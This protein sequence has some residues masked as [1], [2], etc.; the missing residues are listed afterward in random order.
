MIKKLVS[1]FF[2]L[3]FVTLSAQRNSTSSPYS[4][5]GLGEQFSPRTIEQSAMGG[6]GVAFN[7]YKYLNFTNPAAIAEIRYTTYT[8]GVLN[9][10]LT[11]KDVNTSQSGNATNLSYF[12]LA[13]PI[14]KKAGASLGIQPVSSVGYG[15]NNTVLD[16]DGNF[17]EFSSFSGNGGVSRVYGTFGLKV[18]KEL[19][20]G[21]EAGFSFGNTENT[22]T[23][24]RTGVTLFTEFN[25]ETQIR[26][27]VVKVGAQ[28]NKEL[29]NKLRI[30]A[31]ASAKLGN[32]L[33]V[34][35][36]EYLYSVGFNGNGVR[37]SRDTILDNPVTGKYTLPLKITLGAGVGKYDKWYVGVEY[38]GQDAI[39]T[40]GFL[41][42]SSAAF[43][44]GNSNRFSLGG[45][46]LPKMNSISS[47][48]ERVTY[49]AGIRLEK[50][51]L[52][53]DGSGTN[54]NF[55]PID[56]FGISFGLGI[57]LKQL[58][59]LNMGLE[60]GVRGTTDNNLIQENYFNFRLGLSLTDVNWFKKRKID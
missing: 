15:L 27:G 3:T 31:G 4:F 51:G 11:I 18:T 34:T 13:F 23:E 7:H 54:T 39:Q 41:N 20:I 19:S 22:I 9:T 46:Y 24:Q 14:G 25:E 37:V 45:F 44:Y 50:T 1:V 10:N 43:R 60:Y 35:G 36:N 53:V 21:V 57:P 12:A 26:G 38:E 55:T 47:Y 5:F 29:K 42:N 40:S 32:E 52:L 48:W 6:I 59:T 56:D 30:S 49:R 8:F 17:A 58:S 33:D 28:Y 16:A 2:L